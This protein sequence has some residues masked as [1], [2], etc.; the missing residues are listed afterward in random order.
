LRADPQAATANEAQRFPVRPMGH[1]M[2]AIETQAPLK[3]IT[4]IRAE[5]GGER[6]E[7]IEEQ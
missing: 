7:A 6:V 2:G 1:D 5:A 3:G 4:P